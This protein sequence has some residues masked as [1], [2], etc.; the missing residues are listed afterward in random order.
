MFLAEANNSGF[1]YQAVSSAEQSEILKKQWAIQILELSSVDLISTVFN[2]KFPEH[3]HGLGF[4]RNPYSR[5]SIRQSPQVGVATRCPWC[6]RH[7]SRKVNKDDSIQF[8]NGT[9]WTPTMTLGLPNGDAL[10]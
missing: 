10:Y 7:R 1:G 3:V 8:E 4:E 2:T 6:G 5:S 9:R